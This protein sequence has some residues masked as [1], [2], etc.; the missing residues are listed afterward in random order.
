MKIMLLSWVVRC[1]FFYVRT[2]RSIMMA[3]RVID[4]RVWIEASEKDRAGYTKIKNEGWIMKG[5]VFSNDSISSGRHFLSVYERT[6]KNETT[7]DFCNFILLCA[8]IVAPTTSLRCKS[9]IYLYS[10]L[11]IF[12][13][14]LFTFNISILPL[15]YQINQRLCTYSVWINIT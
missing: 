3:F 9:I 2:P 1:I 14:L 4:V 7:A 8:I 6:E 11:L 15:Y 5:K 13:S 12:D 10:F